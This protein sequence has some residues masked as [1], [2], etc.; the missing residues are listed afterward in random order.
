VGDALH[1]R[2]GLGVEAL[3]AGRPGRRSWPE[4]LAALDGGGALTVIE[5]SIG[6]GPPLHVHDR[7]DECFYVMDGELSIHCG[8]DAY[9]ATA[10]SFVFLPPGRPHRF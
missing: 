10:G 8:G 6:A 7:E 4:G 5:I 2:R 1:Q 9:D 3:R